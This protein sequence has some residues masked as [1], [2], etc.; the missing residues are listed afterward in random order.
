MPSQN[1]YGQKT[2]IWF[3]D[4]YI[5]ALITIPIKSTLKV[6]DVTSNCI[7][8]TGLSIKNKD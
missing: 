3:R 8:I 1:F 6:E 5:L 7:K 2:E 4:D